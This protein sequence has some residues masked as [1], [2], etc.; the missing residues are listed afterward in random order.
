MV[1]GNLEVNKVGVAYSGRNTD[2][3]C[4]ENQSLVSKLETVDT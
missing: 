4:Y 1:V 3:K 2:T